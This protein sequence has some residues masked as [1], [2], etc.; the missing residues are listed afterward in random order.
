MTLS[1][2]I[3]ETPR[4]AVLAR[5]YPERL[6]EFE[7]FDTIIHRSGKSW[8]TAKAGVEAWGRLPLYYAERN[9]GGKVTHTGYIT[10]IAV[11]PSD[12]T[13]V[14][15][16]LREHVSPKE[17]YEEYADRLD[18]T[19]FLASH[20]ERLSDPFHQSELRKL[21]GDGSVAETFSREPAYVKQRPVDFPDF[22][23]R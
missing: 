19:T 13:D 15:E 7:R 2:A 12:G 4:G 14:T 6:M 22:P 20:G 10:E 8:K 21:S 3:R 16:R 11:D 23:D 9:S 1:D 18:T 17:T 5:N